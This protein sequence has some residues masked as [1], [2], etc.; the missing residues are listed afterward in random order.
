MELFEPKTSFALNKV[1]YPRAGEFVGRWIIG[2][3]L[4]PMPG[5]FS[6]LQ[7]LYRDDASG[8]SRFLHHNV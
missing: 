2:I 7:L 6:G 3:E 5:H 4:T 1:L 8:N